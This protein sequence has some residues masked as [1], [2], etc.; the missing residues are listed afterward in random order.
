MI[1]YFK[2]PQNLKKYRGSTRTTI[3]SQLNKDLNRIGF[4]MKNIR[5]LEYYHSL[6]QYREEW[7]NFIERITLRYNEHLQTMDNVN[8]IKRKRKKLCANNAEMVQGQ[9]KRCRITT[10]EEENEEFNEETLPMEVEQSEEVA[11]LV[12]RLPR[13][14]FRHAGSTT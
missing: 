13:A 1:E 11:P 10:P 3:A 6:A 4:E 8:R 9:Q 5:Q 14:L 7:R 2:N 12:L